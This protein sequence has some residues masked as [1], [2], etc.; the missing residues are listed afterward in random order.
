MQLADMVAIYNLPPWLHAHAVLNSVDNAITIVGIYSGSDCA[1]T[2]RLVQYGVFLDVILIP[3]DGSCQP[4]LCRSFASNTDYD[5]TAIS[6]C[7][8]TL[9]CSPTQRGPRIADSPLEISSFSRH[10]LGATADDEYAIG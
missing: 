10:G 8:L 4:V 6:Q 9:N 2:L 3:S 5:T 7:I 1:N